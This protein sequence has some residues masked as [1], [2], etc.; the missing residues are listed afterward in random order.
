MSRCDDEPI[1][2]VR[3]KSILYAAI[4]F[5]HNFQD[6]PVNQ[7]LRVLLCL[8]VVFFVNPLIVQS[9]VHKE[10]NADRTK[11]TTITCNY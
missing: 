2:G 3:K 10:H 11:D 7:G 6:I 1:I 4:C 8:L 5:Q 9:W